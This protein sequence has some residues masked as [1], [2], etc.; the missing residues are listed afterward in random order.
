MQDARGSVGS[1]KAGERV[2]APF[3][4]PCYLYH[5]VDFYHEGDGKALEVLSTGLV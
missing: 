2:K 4:R 3:G 1:S 5:K